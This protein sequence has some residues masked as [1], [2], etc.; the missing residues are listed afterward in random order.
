MTSTKDICKEDVSKA[1]S[2]SGHVL[3]VAILGLSTYTSLA[4]NIS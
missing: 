2:T 3:Y 1:D 4:I